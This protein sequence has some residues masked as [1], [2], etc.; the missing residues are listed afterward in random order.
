MSIKRDNP[1]WTDN[2]NLFQNLI[3]TNSK[4]KF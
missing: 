2:L 3:L 1:H 4:V